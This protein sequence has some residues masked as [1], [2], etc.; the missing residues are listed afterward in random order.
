VNVAAGI[1]H[2]RYPVGL[3]PD[4]VRGLREAAQVVL[5]EDLLGRAYA[6][7]G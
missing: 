7:G 1:D 2:R 6:D 4:E 5:L 3:V